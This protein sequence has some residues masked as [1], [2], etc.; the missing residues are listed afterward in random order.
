[1]AVTGA[2]G[3]ASTL[4][5][6]EHPSQIGEA[7]RLVRRLA[8]AAGL[9]VT[10]GGRA[11]IVATE[12][13]TNL[14]L[15]AGG[16]SLIARALRPP[17]GTGVEIL[18]VDRGPGIGDV[19]A[20]LRDGFSTGTT[21]GNGLGA[22]RRLS[23]R[24]DVDSLP[25]KGTVVFSRVLS[26]RG[27][28]EAAGPEI[29][30]VCCAVQGEEH[31]GD[32]W[33]VRSDRGGFSVLVVDGLG[34]GSLAWSA[35]RA[36]A[37]AFAERPEGEAPARTVEACHEAMRG[38]R[39]AALAV[40]RAEPEA[41]GVRYAGVGNVAARIVSAS[42][43]QHLVSMSG[44][45]GQD[46]LRVREFAYAWPPDSTLVVASDGLRTSWS[47]DAYFGAWSRPASL[48]AGMLLRDHERGRDDVTVVVARW[49]PPA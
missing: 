19:G 44:I 40:V 32:L 43:T 21:Q 36:G 27:G 46:P 2:G 11:A 17:E 1:M 12:L 10:D 4:V 48:L 45:A 7:R 16:G 9:D 26:G 47:T 6:V 18:S 8:A 20:A 23:Q 15:H 35:A 29:G 22:V 13:A 30:A 34:H 39:G 14:L 49:R 33:D 25:G 38:T 41:G 28:A 37:A 24:F 3:E 5:R 31:S 42:G